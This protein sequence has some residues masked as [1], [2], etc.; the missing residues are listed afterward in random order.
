MIRVISGN[1]GIGKT[2]FLLDHANDLINAGKGDVVFIDNTNELLTD[3]KHEI[4]Y[5]NI[6]D[7]FVSTQESMYGFI[8]GLIA[9]DFDIEAIL[10]DGLDKIIK[11]ENGYVDFFDN[12]KKVSDKYNIKFYISMNSEVKDIPEYVVKEYAI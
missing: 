2:K 8:C 3:L 10:I 6:T 7:F 4:R 5:I 1:K 9:E 11:S 12:I